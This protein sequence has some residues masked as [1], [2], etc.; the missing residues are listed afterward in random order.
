MAAKII[1]FDSEGRYVY[2]GLLT[3]K[4]LQEYEDVKDRLINEI[5]VIEA[6]L[7]EKYWKV[8]RIL[9]FYYLGKT[10]GDFLDE[11]KVS[12]K[13]RR[14]FWDEIK[15]LAT[16]ET[17]TRSD[18]KS[19]KRSFFEQCYRLSCMDQKIAESKTWRQWQ[20]LLDRDDKN[21][22][23]Y[24]FID[25][26]GKTN[27][28]EDE[29]RELLKIMNF[30]L[31]EIDTTVFDDNEV[32][33]LYHS[34]LSMSKIWLNCIE[35]FE[36]NHPKSLKLQNKPKWSIKFYKACVDSM[37]ADYSIDEKRMVNIF[38]EVMM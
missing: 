33:A 22:E 30:Y 35:Q 26:I 36:K 3:S 19:K 8:N 11:F 29:W 2:K 21:V 15:F 32:Y 16:S 13:E 14:L 7:K 28:S 6:E 5:P 4:E 27:I 25:W 23:D 37:V 38:E 31:D 12:V 18:G 24:R 9:Y 1:E 17:H 34:M 10:L 20:S